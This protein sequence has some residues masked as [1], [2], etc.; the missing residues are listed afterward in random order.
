MSATWERWF[1]L[2]SEQ[3]LFI[4]RDYFKKIDDEK[5][6]LEILRQILSVQIEI[7]KGRQKYAEDHD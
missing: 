1:A 7:E 4:I 2:T 3:R 5:Y 6:Q